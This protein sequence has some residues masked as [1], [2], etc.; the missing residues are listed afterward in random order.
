MR[1]RSL[2]LVAAVA[3]AH[4]A[5]YNVHQ[6]PDWGVSWTDQGGYQRLGEVL[7]AT[8]QFTRYP[9]AS[10][11]VPEVIRTPGYPAYVALVYLAFGAGN[12]MALAV[13]QAFVFA[14]LCL[15]V[16]A[17]ARRI[18]TERN[19]LAAA[20][21][22]ALFPPFPYFAALAL[23]EL[24]TAFVLSLAMLACIHA[25]QT[26]R[27]SRYALAGVL[28]SLTT[29]VR[30]AFVL[31]PFFL[32]FA[33]PMLVRSARKR[34]ALVGWA[35]LCLAAALTLAPWLTYNYVHL[36][37]LTLSPAGGVGRGL[38]EASWQGRWPGRIQAALTEAA[39]ATPDRAELDRKA[40][41]I[42]E[43]SGLDP[44][45]MRVYVHEWRT[46]HDMWDTPTD[47]MER[48]DARIAADR[49]YLAAAVEHM[50]EDPVGHV[51]RRLTRGPFVLWAAEIPVRYTSI[52]SLPVAA[53]RGM[54]LLQVL[55]LVAAAL[56]AARLARGGRW[57]E[58]TVLV[59]PLVY[60]TAVHLPLLCEARQSLPVKP[61]V[62]I[63]AIAGFRKSE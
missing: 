45:P 15:I 54:W 59:L 7:A 14:A 27:L 11:F 56:G 47:P 18:T 33:V 63:L 8:G 22:A 25:A 10:V 62:I 30:P 12:Q 40:F 23:T 60:V 16:F 46:I 50:R 13:T 38:W 36:G 32:A 1:A 39:D 41:A 19:A 55:L 26:G 21:L 5:A 49:A 42:A 51:I 28:F 61:L 17:I 2:L 35:F 29:L 52:N 34:R 6:Q 24:W 4:A 43:E 37:R 57:L 44:A 20:W 58:T 48:A 53:I 31:L 9:D 3:L